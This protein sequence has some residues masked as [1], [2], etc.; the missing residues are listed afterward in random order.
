MSRQLGKA[1]QDELITIEIERLNEIFKDLS[2]DK[3]KVAL[4]LIERVAFMTI[5]LQ[6]LEDQ[7]KTQGPV[8]NFKN[9]KQQMVVEH[10]AQKS[11]NSMIQR[12]ATAYDK[13]FNLLP[14]DD[15]RNINNED[16]DGF[17]SFVNDR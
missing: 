6:L 14:K 10:P 12:Y 3:K 11:Y 17:E 1:K 8:Y 7:I 5:T 9:G 15:P 16:D 2:E 4:R 13:L